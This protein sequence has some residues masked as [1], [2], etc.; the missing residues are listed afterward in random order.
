MEEESGCFLVSVASLGTNVTP[1]ADA[2][3]RRPVQPSS[4]VP[5]LASALRGG[6][7]ANDRLESA[8]ATKLVFAWTQARGPGQLYS[9]HVRVTGV[10]SPVRVEANEISQN[11]YGP[12]MAHRGSY[13]PHRAVLPNPVV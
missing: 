8:G 7:M 11:R 1:S 3:S 10:L 6:Y 5:R 2:L 9:D 12:I 4:A 13:C